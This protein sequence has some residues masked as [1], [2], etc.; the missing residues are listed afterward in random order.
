VKTLAICLIACTAVFLFLSGTALHAGSQTSRL[1]GCATAAAP[2]HPGASGEGQGYSG[3]GVSFSRSAG[4]E[5]P[6][7]W[8]FYGLLLVMVLY[9]GFIYLS[10][11]DESNLYY[12]L[13]I[14]GFALCLLASSGESVRGLW[15]GRA[16]WERPAIPFFTS[17]AMAS[18]IML[19]RSFL[20]TRDLSFSLDRAL[21]ADALLFLIPMPLSLAIGSN[22][23]LHVVM[24]ILPLSIPLLAFAGYASLD[25]RNSE[26]L[27]YLASLGVFVIGLTIQ[28]GRYYGLLPQAFMTTWSGLMGASCLVVVFSLGME[29]RLNT[30]RRSVARARKELVDLH[31]R[32]D[33]ERELVLVTLKCMDEGLI[34]TDTGGRIFLMNCLAGEITGHP[35][36]QAS[37]RDVWEVLNPVSMSTGKPDIL[38]KIYRSMGAV[39]ITREDLLILGRDNTP[40]NIACRCSPLKHGN[41]EIRGV[42]IAFTDVTRQ[43]KYEEEMIRSSK[44]GALC[45]LA[46]GIAHDF[47]NI[48]TAIV[49]NISLAR[50]KNRDNGIVTGILADIEAA[51]Y[52][53]KELTHRLLTFSKGGAP[54]KA[55]S[56]I[57]NLLTE[58]VGFHLTGSNV[59]VEMDIEGN[60]WSA[61]I[62]QGQMS[63]VIGNIVINAKQAM[64][65]GGRL[66]VTAMNVSIDKGES[67][68][69]PQGKY[70]RVSIR[71]EGH[72]IPHECLGKIFDPFYTTKPEGSG[73]GLASSCS[74]VRNHEGGIEVASSPGEGAEFI[75][76]LPATEEMVRESPAQDSTVIR[77]SGRVLLMDDEYIILKSIG[78]L[79]RALG[80]DVVCVRN[81]FEAIKAYREAMNSGKSYDLVIVDLI[82]PGSMGGK[83]AVQKLLEIDPDAKVVVTSGYSNDPIISNHQAYGF[84]GTIIKPFT[85]RTLSQAISDV[86][87]IR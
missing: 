40:C 73:L 36:D 68:C 79:I 14:L 13:T 26:A 65:E 10:L 53:A 1:P 61:S 46:G 11:R 76:Y 70:L 59:K 39:D 42:I 86:L 20:K 62:D 9:N 38:Q 58:V 29:Y 85:I 77:G 12:S 63:H 2:A 72:G 18:F 47:N 49:G 5:S 75:I 28:A 64:P 15:P 30:L 80:Y 54:V 66:W 60:L 57:G 25:R 71:D 74:I 52:R 4:G 7:L 37:G 32:L 33:E 31:A 82:I 23:A 43:R 45:T 67:A 69:V 83:D 48:L 34:V 16:F 35:V 22:A 50:L 84:K 51:S 56:D 78:G 17:M 24:L 19:S 41:G 21:L 87:D 6:V 44:L 81:G 55:I 3:Q 27:F 8:M